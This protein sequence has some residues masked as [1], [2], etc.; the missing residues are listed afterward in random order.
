[1][2]TSSFE[3]TESVDLYGLCPQ[4]SDEELEQIMLHGTVYSPPFSTIFIKIY[5]CLEVISGFCE[6]PDTTV[7]YEVFFT[8]F[9][10]SLD[11]FNRTHPVSYSID[12]TTTIPM[13]RSSTI[14]RR[15]ILSRVILMDE[16]R[17]YSDST[18]MNNY[19]E[20]EPSDTTTTVRDSAGH[21]CNITQF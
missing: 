11:P 4:V 7:Q 13:K 10:Y 19:T 20:L 1:M 21:L 17:D 12:A 15:E 6:T 16:S 3:G 9:M 5:P 18:M 14:S 2:T 8:H